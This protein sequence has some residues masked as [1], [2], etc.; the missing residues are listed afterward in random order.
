M[1]KALFLAAILT[2]LAEPVIAQSIFDGFGESAP[3]DPASAELKQWERAVSRQM[4]DH[5]PNFTNLGHG[6]V[7]VNFCVDVAGRV[8]KEKLG[9]YSGNAQAL[10]AASVV[11]SL[12][13]PPAPPTVKAK[14]RGDC[15]WFQQRFWFH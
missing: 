11:S 13:L 1:I 10:I 15:Y 7:T 5:T 2:M 6:R 12:K 9:E 14:L 3:Q 8:V 4:F